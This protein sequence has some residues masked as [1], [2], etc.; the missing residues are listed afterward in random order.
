M[1]SYWQSQHPPTGSPPPNYSAFET[2]SGRRDST[3]GPSSSTHT[4]HHVHHHLPDSR[5]SREPNETEPLLSSDRQSGPSNVRNLALMFLPV[6]ISLLYCLYILFL[7]PRNTPAPYW[8]DILRGETCN[9]VG[10]R[11]YTATLANPPKSNKLEACQ[12]IRISLNG[13]TIRSAPLCSILTL[14]GTTIVQGSWILDFDESDCFPVWSPVSAD[15][16]S[17]YGKRTYHA[18]LD[19]PPG[20]DA[21]TSCRETPAIIHEQSVHPT[22][23]ELVRKHDGTSD[24]AAKGYW[25]VEDAS[26]APV[27]SPISAEGC[28]S[29]GKR[30][31]HADL[32]VP[33]G[34]DALTSCR[35]TPAIIQEQSVHPTQCEL[36][37]KQDGTSDLAV[38]GHWIME[39]ASCTPRWVSVNA[40]AQC[41]AYDK[42]R[43]TA[44]LEGIPQELDPLQTC[45]EAPSQLFNMSRKPE[46]CDWDEQGRVVGTWYFGVPECRP[47]LRRV[48]DMGCLESGLKVYRM[49]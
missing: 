37:R 1:P 23:C 41:A 11:E 44:I 24:L 32:D 4:H 29:Y 39:D 43:Y 9:A 33:P 49:C 34:L 48:L 40:D 21:L 15:A 18:D 12:R 13:R 6:S 22:Q 35:E 7:V 25:I 28:I 19:V 30:P 45:Y 31:Y 8:K 38:K 3:P 20:L 14:N 2:H 46:S 36:V 47:V 5:E 16:C 27:W 17:S 10:A 42:K 26:C